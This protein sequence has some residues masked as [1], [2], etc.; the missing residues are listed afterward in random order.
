MISVKLT[1]VF[2][3]TLAQSMKLM[4]PYS[5]PVTIPDEQNLVRYMQ[6]REMEGLSRQKRSSFNLFVPEYNVF[7][8]FSGC[9][10]T[11]RVRRAQ[12]LLKSAACRTRP[13]IG[14]CREAQK[15]A[16]RCR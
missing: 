11:D 12:F 7:N 5:P 8:Q 4:K 6:N 10:I 13:R 2:L 16:N 3:A 14:A 9:R 15:Y 1:I